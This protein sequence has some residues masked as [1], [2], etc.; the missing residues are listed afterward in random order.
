MPRTVVV[1]GA[2]AGVGRATAHEL[3]RSEGARVALLARG[4]VGL[5]NAA[6]E[7]REL[8]GTALPI[9]CDV[10]DAEAVEAAAAQ[11][12]A[13]L[14]PIDVWINNAMVSSLSPF[15]EM[16]VDE[17]QR[18][19]DVTYHGFVHGTRAA[20]KRFVPRGAGVVVQVGSS[21]AYRGIPL[22]SAYCGAKHAIQGFTE[23]VRCEL[24]HEGSKVHLTMV[25]LPAINTPQFGMVRNRLPKH[26]MPVPPI[27]EPEVAA[28]AIVWA[29]LHRRREVWLGAS[30]PATILGN[31]IAPTAMDHMLA[32]TGWDSQMSEYEPETKPDYL[33]EPRDE[34]P[35]VRGRFSDEAKTSSRQWAL[36]TVV[37]DWAAGL[38]SAAIGRA[39]GKLQQ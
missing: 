37:P 21:L 5:E 16:E 9:V 26:P 30:T 12:E 29:S 14:G 18:I 36:T 35:G 31:A 13:E 1:T 7:V 4:R 25:Q 32:T 20:L 2:S 6:R 27:Y 15:S 34:D 22:Q 33:F 23:A 28:R 17:F 24:L 39:M 10:S 11:A 3:A 19:T 38:V 8:G